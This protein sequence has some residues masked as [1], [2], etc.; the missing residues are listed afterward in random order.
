VDPETIS[1]LIKKYA[2]YNAYKYHGRAEGDAVMSKLMGECPELRPIAKDVSKTLLN[3]LKEVNSLTLQEQK[4]LLES[5]APEL[6][7]HVMS[8]EKKEKLPELPNNKNIIMRF[9][10]NPNG[11]PTLGSARGIVINSEYTQM[12]SG[13]FILRFDDTDPQTKRP[14]LEAYDWYIEDC[15]WLLTKPDLVVIASDRMTI[16]Y[17]YAEK[18]VK[19]GA[20]YVCTCSQKEF[21]RLKEAMIPC[22]DRN[23]TAEENLKLWEDMLHGLFKEKEA[24]LRIKTDIKHKNPALRDWICFRIIS[25][26]HPRG[27]DYRVWPTLD[28]E[29]AIED[30]L[31][32]V[33]HILRGK[34]L[35]DSEG[36]QQ[37][38]YN[39]LG[40]QYPTTIHWGRIS[41]YEFGKFSTSEIKKA[42]EKGVY[43]GWDDPRLPTIRALRRR[44]FHPEAIRRFMIN[45]GV[46]ESDIRISL[47]NLYAENRK[48]IDVSARR[49]FFV[50]DPIRMEIVAV[51]PTTARPPLHPSSK[52][53]FREIKVESEIFISSD[54][55]KFAPG[56]IIRLKD[57]YN[58]KITSLEPLV[59][60]Y[61]GDERIRRLK[62]IH[63]A[64]TNGFKV[65]VLT[66]EGSDNGIGELGI[67]SE[68]NN[69]IQF[70]RYGFVRID[71][72]VKQ[73]NETKIVAYFTHQ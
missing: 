66:P 62:I 39:Y 45:L 57:L 13:T 68:L 25:A 67:A 31:L 52:L 11:P 50:K 42:I 61:S 38:L 69:V 2:L 14:V 28:F 26:P 10:P 58:V 32:N 72:I 56:D 20:A 29:S 40:W 48:V 23:R 70:E 59:A 1:K 22:P 30:H 55:I 5:F 34:D 60:E 41:I 47:E 64:P 65:E 3:V 15:E 35:R 4:K 36:R 16:Y 6:L 54:D 73:D 46:S 51:T 27:L 71:D 7:K 18:L 12:Y 8:E 63:W 37:F 43:R 49:Y 9:A 21:K 44:G 33:T 53:G 19:L 24:V 17:S